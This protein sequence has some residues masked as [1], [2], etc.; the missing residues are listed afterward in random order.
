MQLLFK[1]IRYWREYGNTFFFE[2]ATAVADT[3]RAAGEVKKKALTHFVK[4]N[5]KLELHY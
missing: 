3:P 2:D 1:T 5:W 4:L